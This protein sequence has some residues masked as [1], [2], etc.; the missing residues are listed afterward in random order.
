MLM[1]FHSIY[2]TK[3]ENILYYLKIAKKYFRLKLQ[4]IVIKRVMSK[5]PYKLQ[6][7]S[8]NGACKA[9]LCVREII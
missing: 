7:N 3:Y 8:A 4:N 2:F 1:Y 9:K 6:S 5:A